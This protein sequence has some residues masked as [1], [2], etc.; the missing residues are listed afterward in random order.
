MIR[1]RS[2]HWNQNVP[3]RKEKNISLVSCQR[4]S[5]EEN[6]ENLVQ[7]EAID[8]LSCKKHSNQEKVIYK[9]VVHSDIVQGRKKGKQISIENCICRDRHIDI[10]IKF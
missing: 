10:L 9:S 7:G 4:A 8:I 3:E 6:E 5:G 2:L 1:I